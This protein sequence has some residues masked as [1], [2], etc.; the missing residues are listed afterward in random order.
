MS[1]ALMGISVGV[2]WL[3]SRPTTVKIP[4]E[5]NDSSSYDESNY[6]E[7]ATTT[8]VVDT[9]ISERPSVDFGSPDVTMEV[10]GVGGDVVRLREVVGDPQHLEDLPSDV[11]S[12][13]QSCPGVTDR[14]MVVQIDS[15]LDLKSSMPAEVSVNYQTINQPAVFAFSSGMECASGSVKHTLKPDSD[16]KI[17]YWVV[18]TGAV[19]P[20]H[21]NGN[22][23]GV[24]WTL[25]GPDPMLPNLERYTWKAWGPRVLNCDGQWG[26]SADIQLTRSTPQGCQPVTTKQTAVGNF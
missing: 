23:A 25:N 10:N 9:T 8:E 16:S 12:V 3:E 21:P 19:T 15:K 11:S 4:L 17:T 7:P 6:Y 26:H 14:D 2:I 13:I 5:T 24:G 20:N 1:M 22:F 18:L